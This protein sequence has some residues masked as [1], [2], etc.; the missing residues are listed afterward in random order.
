VNPGDSKTL[1][2]N[3]EGNKGYINPLN[4]ILEDE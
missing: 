3:L 2:R 4:R 1:I